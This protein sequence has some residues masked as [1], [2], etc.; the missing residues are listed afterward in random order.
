ML[1][2]EKESTCCGGQMIL[3]T[4]SSIDVDLDAMSDQVVVHT[5]AFPSRSALIDLHQQ[6]PSSPSSSFDKSG[7]QLAVDDW[8]LDNADDGQ[9]EETSLTQSRLVAAFLQILRYDR[10]DTP[11]QVSHFE[12]RV[13][14]KFSFFSDVAT[15]LLFRPHER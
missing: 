2:D 4:G 8:T 1:V 5:I 9:E 10:P 15:P 6:L 11:T 14:F 3:L 13:L 12:N 7:L